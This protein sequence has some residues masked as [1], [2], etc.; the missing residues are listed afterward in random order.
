MGFVVRLAKN[1]F[2]GTDET[3]GIAELLGLG[4]SDVLMSR[5]L[6]LSG[7]WSSGT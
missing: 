1:V 2:A 7:V 5:M 4:A 3:A 6:D